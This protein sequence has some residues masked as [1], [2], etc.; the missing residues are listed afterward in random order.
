[1]P[2]T[3]TISE[4]IYLILEEDAQ[5]KSISLDALV[6]KLL[7]E[8]IEKS[9]KSWYQSFRDKMI[10]E[11]PELENRSREDVLKEFDRLSNKIAQSIHFESLLWV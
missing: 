11:N 10:K 6:E 1:M 7:S 9:T 8:S 2:K 3:I 4:D 5:N